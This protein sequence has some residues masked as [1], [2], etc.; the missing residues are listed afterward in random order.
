MPQA[1]LLQYFSGVVLKTLTAVEA[2][3]DASNQ[4]EYNGNRDLVGL[5]GRATSKHRF[6]ARFVYVSDDRTP[7]TEDASV[8]WY[9]A[10][11]N[12]PS[13]SEHRLYFPTTNVSRLAAAGDLLVIGMLLDKAVLVVIAKDGSS[14]AEDLRRLFGMTGASDVNFSVW[15][16]ED[17]LPASEAR[18]LLQAVGI[19]D[20]LEGQP[21]SELT[22][23]GSSPAQ[24]D[25]QSRITEFQIDSIKSIQML[26]WSVP[27]T[28][29][30]GWHV[31]VGIN[32]SGKTTALRCI[33]LALIAGK[34]VQSL[35]PRWDTWVTEGAD[36]GNVLVKCSGIIS[37]TENIV[38]TTWSTE[39]SGQTERSTSGQ[40]PESVFSVGYGP[41]RRFSGGDADIRERVS[42]RARRHITLFS[43]QADLADSLEWLRRLY[44]K[45]LEDSDNKLNREELYREVREFVN[46]ALRE[47]NTL[48]DEVTTDR[49]SFKT[50]NGYTVAIE[51]LSDG[52]RSVLSL[53]LNILSHLLDGDSSLG[54]FSED[55][56]YV[57]ASG[58]VLIDEVDVHLHP[59]W[60]QDIGAWFKKHFPKFQ[61]IVATHS[62]FVCQSADSIF[63]LPNPGAGGSGHMLSEVELNQIKYGTVLDGYGTGVFGPGVD[64]SEESRRYSRRLATLNLKQLREGLTLEERQEQVKLRGILP[65]GD[66]LNDPAAEE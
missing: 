41:F 49:I 12:H 45:S 44:F 37:S 66:V 10:R 17:G 32:G 7:L 5:F 50:E 57:T 63:I 47:S 8:T 39:I 36:E 40:T 61:F 60:Q 28:I 56:A 4:H 54:V 48:L 58:I 46:N 64:E 26:R 18:S 2:S 13:R 16:K 62:L 31:L 59:K 15:K 52:F 27:A 38:K 14:I 30:A 55:K 20:W 23:T 9:D 24:Q 43:E 29:S 6:A 21:V 51:E 33:A 22:F 65:T 35:V 25:S 11:Q 34:D 19:L 1:F 3:T 53:V 42:P